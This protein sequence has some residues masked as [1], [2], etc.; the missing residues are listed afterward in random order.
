MG[1]KPQSP[2]LS[3]HCENEGF[4]SLKRK[5]MTVCRVISFAGASGF[6]AKIQCVDARFGL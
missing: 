3:W 2:R 4:L 1:E 5:R 6:N